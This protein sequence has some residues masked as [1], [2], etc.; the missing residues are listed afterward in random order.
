MSSQIARN[1]RHGKSIAISMAVASQPHTQRCEQIL[2]PHG[3]EAGKNERREVYDTSEVFDSSNKRGN[4]KNSGCGVRHKIGSRRN[5]SLAKWQSGKCEAETTKGDL[6]NG[7]ERGSKNEC[8]KQS[9]KGSR[10]NSSHG[11][12]ASKR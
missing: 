2:E 1:M 4:E 6:L 8:G 9:G 5:I 10:K 7:E 3:K 11:E 12:Q